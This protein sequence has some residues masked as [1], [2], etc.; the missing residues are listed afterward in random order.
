MSRIHIL[1]PLVADQIAAGEV[2][3]R[4]ASVVKELVEN[5][6]D[7]MATHI[8][9]QIE[10]GGRQLIAVQD[11]GLGMDGEDLILSVRRHATS[12][13]E[14]LE[15]LTRSMTLGFRG[16][17]LAA[18]SAVSRTHLF[19][20]PRDQAY[21][22]HLVVDGGQIGELVPTPMAEGTLIRVEELFF[23]VPARLKALKSA[24]AELGAIQQLLQHYAIGYA[25]VAIT[26]RDGEKILW[27]TIGNGQVPDVIFQLFGSE[28]ADSLL[29]VQYE[30]EGLIIQGFICPAI[31]NRGTRQGQSL[32]IN[33][34]WV[35]NWV[36]RNAIE[37]AF[38]P[39]LPDRRYP[40]FWLFITV[41]GSEVDPNAH[42][43]KSEVRL[44]HERFIA[45]KLYHAVQASLAAN[46]PS[47][48]LSVA[49][50]GIEK[51][52][53][54]Y[55]SW[56]DS[57]SSMPSWNWP[58][59][60]GPGAVP[61]LHDEYKALIP[62]AQWQAK[63]IIAQGPFGLYLIDQHAAHER[64]YYEQFRRKGQEILV[65]QPLLIPYTY[66]CLPGE[67]AKWREYRDMFFEMG[68]D[69]TEVGGTT[70]MVRAIP[71]GLMNSPSDSGGII[72]TVLESLADG[73]HH[74]DHPIFWTQETRY[75]LAACKAAIKAYRV[76]TIDEMQA[77]LD[78]MATVDDPRGCP[79]GRPT[80][81]HLTLEEVDRRFGRKG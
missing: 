21:G 7:A 69:I 3:E 58:P 81:L 61:V 73:E 22:F 80:T 28:I 44:D 37:E 16:E 52:A 41:D 57:E 60:S 76:L 8:D 67:W 32:Y 64:V 74:H 34:R 11:D 24:H 78:M 65:A 53:Q 2:V 43:T 55:V 38:R 48:P 35:N 77:L 63:Y 50:V 33:R 19:S 25:D 75:A 31:K 4:P 70:L 9:V 1:D 5:S 66:T 68:F 18:I 79:H 45:G 40:Y 49:S 62:L 10:D 20:R 17:A 29:P 12:K 23:N 36:L 54:L 39:H 59:E 13:I 15:D 30:Q 42:P 27:N 6:L 71:Q 46:S 72:R 56:Q 47:E 26:L 14:V 51:P